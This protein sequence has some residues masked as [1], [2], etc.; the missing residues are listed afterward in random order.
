[1]LHGH[2]HIPR[3]T[4]HDG[5]AIVGCGSSVGK[6]GTRDGQPYMSINVVSVDGKERRVT[7][8]LLAERI[9]GGGLVEQQ[10]H[11]LVLRTRAGQAA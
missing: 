5:T 6:V 4:V 10:R 11:E 1:L 3:A 8:R 2:K 7:S 9:P